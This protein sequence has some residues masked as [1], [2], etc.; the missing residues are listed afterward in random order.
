MKKRIC[1]LATLI[2]FILALASCGK[3]KYGVYGY[4]IKEDL[5]TT[6]IIDDNYGNYYEIFVRSF[7]DS[8]G[9]G[10][11]DQ[12]DNNHQHYIYDKN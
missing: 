8:D 5:T 2:V 10:I 7:Y 6:N 3:G 1:L 11:V 9:N 4:R 12:F